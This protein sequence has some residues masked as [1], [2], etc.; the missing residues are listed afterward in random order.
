MIKVTIDPLS[1]FCFGVVTAV[2]MVEKFLA[3]NPEEKLYCLGSI[4][5]NAEEVNR[6]EK[7]GMT[8]I[9]HEELAKMK[10]AKI[11][12]RAHGEP[13]STYR[14]I[15]DNS[16]QLID[17]TC[18]VV[19]KLQQ[20][21]KQSYIENPDSQIIIFGKKGHAEVIGLQ[22]Q[23]NNKALVISDKTEI[24]QYINP[25]K[26]TILFSQTTMPQSKF[27][28][29]AQYLKDFCKKGV[30]VH[31]SICRRVSN[32]EQELRKFVVKHDVI[33][34]ISGKDSSNGKLL[35]KACLQKNPNTYFVSSID[36]LQKEWFSDQ[37][38]VGICGATSTPLWLM[39]KVAA[40]IENY[41]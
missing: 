41:F 31:D 2:N 37:T 17:A 5:H 19:L 39:E 32:R 1:G 35:Y 34:F 18:P 7:K 25:D 14:L 9:T 40:E 38:T 13:P 29:V 10:S 26:P 11:M 16:H 36:E 3:D 8:T 24:Q 6:L 4:M 28:E 21:I 15:K 20:R 12:I 22:G 33:I 27:D 23:T 30:E